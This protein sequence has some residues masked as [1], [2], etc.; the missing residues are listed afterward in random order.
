M[1][2]R[3]VAQPALFV[4][5]LFGLLVM[6]H[7]AHA[8]SG[9]GATAQHRMGA[10][11]S[12]GHVLATHVARTSSVHAESDDPHAATKPADPTT[13]IHAPIAISCL[14]VLLG[15]VAYLALRLRRAGRPADLRIGSP[16]PARAATR[17]AGRGPPRLL[18]AQ[19]CVLRT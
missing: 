5:L 15:A 11:A 10:G 8:D 1:H 12:T 6:P 4:A 7:T 19:I 16:L 14:V 17:P 9:A 18:L 13:P 2:L 3:A